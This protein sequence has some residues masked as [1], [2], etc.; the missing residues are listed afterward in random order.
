MGAQLKATLVLQD[1]MTPKLVGV[2]NKVHAAGAKMA[3]AFSNVGRAVF[4]LRSLM[5]TLGGAA[6]VR[7]LM[8]TAAASDQFKDRLSALTKNGRTSNS[9]A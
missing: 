2:V 7:S 3:S 4:S 5:V 1:G 9:R 6:V 8:A